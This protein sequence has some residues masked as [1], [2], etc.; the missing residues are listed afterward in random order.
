MSDEILLYIGCGNKD[1]ESGAAGIWL[2]SLDQDSGAMRVVDQ[3]STIEVCHY[4]NLSPDRQFL[5]ATAIDRSAPKGQSSSVHAFAVDGSGQLTHL[6][7]QAAGGDSPCYIS[8][9]QERKVLLMVNYTGIDDLGSVRTFAIRP[10]GTIGEQTAMIQHEGGSVHTTRQRTSH[11]HMVIVS[12]D[13]RLAM[14]SDLGTDHVML[15]DLNEGLL[16]PNDPPSLK[17]PDGAGPRHM[18]FSPDA[19]TL[20]VINELDSTVCVYRWGPPYTL[21][22]TLSALPAGYEGE[23]YCADLHVTPSGRF[24]YGSNRGHDSIVIYAADAESGELSLV[25]HQSTGGSW[26][27]AFMLTPSGGML[28]AANQYGNSLCSFHLDPD[29][30]QLTATGHALETPEPVCVKAWT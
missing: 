27:R 7:Q 30:G 26:P 13:N 17:L 3:V 24:V 11:P 4:L 15:Y 25:G 14:V 12:P 9:D 5:Y 21:L 18:A 22:Q 2:V 29:S 8:V 23:S 20:Y 19:R 10:D 16:A 1:V 28:V 6:N